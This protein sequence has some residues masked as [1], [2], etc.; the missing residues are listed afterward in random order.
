MSEL[1]GWLGGDAQAATPI[2]EQLRLGVIEAVRDGRLPA[3][4]R[5]P[6]VQLAGELGLAVNTVARTYR[7]LETA[8]VVETRGSSGRFIVSGRDPTDA[9]MMAAAAVYAEAARRWR[10]RRGGA[11]LSRC[12]VRSA[13]IQQ[14]VDAP[15][16]LH[17]PEMPECRKHRL[18]DE[19]AP[20]GIGTSC[21]ALRPGTRPPARAAG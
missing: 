17:G 18:E 20:G 19:P 2:F 21:T 11:A 1:A 7:E 14:R 5:L 15:E 6:T 10:G 13:E 4:S 3:G 16:R 9:A 8:G 12:R